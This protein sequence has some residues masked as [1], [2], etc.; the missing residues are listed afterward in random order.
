MEHAFDE[1][2]PFIKINKFENA[3]DKREQRGFKYLEW[4]L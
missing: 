1:N 3:D 2:T 4:E